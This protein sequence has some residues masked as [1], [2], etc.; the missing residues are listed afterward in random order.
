MNLDM[1]PYIYET[2]DLL[3]SITKNCGTLIDQTQTKT[4]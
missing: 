4:T 1:I 2:E 3:L